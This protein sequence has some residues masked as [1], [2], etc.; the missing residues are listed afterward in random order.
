MEQTFKLVFVGHVDHGKS[1]LIGRLLADTNALMEGVIERIEKICKERGK[2]FEYAF[3]VDTLQ[4]EQEQGITI[5]TTKIEFSTKN[6]NYTIID[7]PG[8]KEFLKNMISGASNA[9]A[10]ILIIDAKEGVKEQTKR[11]AYILSLLGIKKIL[12]VINK[13]DLIS[14]SEDTFNKVKKEINNYLSRLGI[15]PD[16]YIPISAKLGLNVVEKSEKMP[17]YSGKTVLDSIDSFEKDKCIEDKPLRFPIQD[18]YKFDERRIIAGRIESGQIKEGQDIVILPSNSK[19]VVKKIESWPN[20]RRHSASAGE[21]IGITVND[22]LF[23]KRGEMICLEKEKPM[24]SNFIRCNVFWMGDNDL[25]QNKKY[26]LKI[27]T[28]EV[29]CEVYTINNVIDAETLETIHDKM[30]LSKN[31]VGDIIIKTKKPI[32]FDAFQDIPTTGRFVI[33]D[34]YI[35]CGGGI[36]EKASV[37]LKHHEKIEPKVGFISPKRSL[38]SSEERRKRNNHAGKAIWITGLPGAGKNDIAKVLERRLF[39]LGKQVYYLDAANVRLSL[40]SDLDFTEKGRHEQSRRLAEVA[41][42]LVNAGLIVIVST[43]SPF[44]AD[45]NYARKIIGEDNYLE[46]FVNTHLDICKKN[47]PHGIYT[48]A[49]KEKLN[50]IPG[51]DIEYEKSEYPV[52]ELKIKEQNFNVEEKVEKIISLLG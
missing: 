45:R 19:T 51:I 20:N 49:E 7:A 50:G 22:E 18:V 36:I 1:T 30:A 48:R 23:L 16:H 4:E 33:V 29:D 5:D 38:V 12:V 44:K 34:D 10:A 39:D 52:C 37:V 24:L 26:K 3:V 27:N 41:N 2:E 9:E 25:V 43:V 13:M 31:E 32:S 42:I 46:V 8:H 17:W 47:N 35:V 40:S 28:E 14:F 6:R 11:H 21:C 15:I